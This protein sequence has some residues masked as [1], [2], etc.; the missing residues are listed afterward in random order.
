MSSRSDVR[1]KRAGAERASKAKTRAA[2]SARTQVPGKNVP[3]KTVVDEALC[4]GW[5]DGLVKRVDEAAYML[6]DL[7]GGQRRGTKGGCGDGR[8]IARRFRQ[9]SRGSVEPVKAPL[10]WGCAAIR[11][12]ARAAS[13]SERSSCDS[14]AGA[15]GTSTGTGT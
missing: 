10:M 11:A 13:A 6:R 4:F 8:E 9:R 5:I 2:P 7:A 3:G 14:D 1:G 12:L 15:A